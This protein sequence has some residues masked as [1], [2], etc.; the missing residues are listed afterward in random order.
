MPAVLV[1]IGFGTNTEEA[2]YMTDAK[3]MDEL[4]SAISDAVLEYLKRY[5]RRVALAT[6][7]VPSGG[8]PGS[9]PQ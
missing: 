7:A 4:S 6:E 1:E 9:P 2:A 3:K 5:E 8:P